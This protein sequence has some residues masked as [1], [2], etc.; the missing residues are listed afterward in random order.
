MLK[1]DILKQ[2]AEK[3]SINQCH[4]NIEQTIWALHPTQPSSYGILLFIIIIII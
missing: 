3:Q 2:M 4:K 1:V